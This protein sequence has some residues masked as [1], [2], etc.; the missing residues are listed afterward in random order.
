MGR[1]Y[2]NIDLPC[3]SSLVSL[4]LYFTS[5]FPFLLHGALTRPF[6]FDLGHLFYFRSEM[7]WQMLGKEG[8]AVVAPWPIAEEED[9][10]MTREAK[11]LRD[12]LKNF[13]AQQGK[14]KKGSTKASILVSDDYP[15]WKIDTLIWMQ[16]K[17]DADTGFN[18]TFMKD[19][20]T[21][22]GS[23]PDKKMIKFTM[24]FASFIKKEVEDVGSMAMDI[25]LPF[26]QKEI[27]VASDGYIKSQLNV[28]ELDIINL[29]DTEGAASDVPER[30]KENVS[31][32]KPVLWLR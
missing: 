23:N 9:K 30:T 17:F 20:K 29:R 15:Q 18:A 1:E 4:F 3:L 32:G 11:F 16:G 14:A 25:Q 27:L 12:T 31:P 7:L 2:R 6:S 22:T 13:R 5:W 21:W 10:I 19:L 24:Q 26:D 28:T 8:L